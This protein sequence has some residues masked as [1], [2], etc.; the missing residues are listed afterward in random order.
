MAD[1]AWVEVSQGEWNILIFGYKGMAYV[2]G[3]VVASAAEGG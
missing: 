2:Q 3:I 1:N